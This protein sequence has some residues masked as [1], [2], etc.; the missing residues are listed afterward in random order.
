M[1]DRAT[2]PA[3]GVAALLGL[4]VLLGA[5]VAGAALTVASVDSPPSAALTL[6]V[7]DDRLTIAHAGGDDLD[8]RELRLRV[9]VDGEELSHQPSVP[10]FSARGFESGPSGPFNPA[11]DPEWTAGETATLRVAGTNEPPI[12]PGSRVVVRISHRDAPIARL[13]ATS[14]GAEKRGEISRNGMRRVETGRD[15]SSE[16]ETVAAS[17]ST[18]PARGRPW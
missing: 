4:T 6:S 3:V 11:A 17:R 1:S 18:P 9:R 13:S 16:E 15:E 7:S 2:V 5:A 10:F 12:R 8:V 14:S